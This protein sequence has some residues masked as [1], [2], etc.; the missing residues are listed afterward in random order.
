ML[1]D[2]LRRSLGLYGTNKCLIKTP[3]SSVRYFPS[4]LIWNKRRECKHVKPIGQNYGRPPKPQRTVS[5]SLSSVR[6]SVYE[7]CGSRTRRGFSPSC[8]FKCNVQTVGV[9]G[10]LFLLSQR[11]NRKF[12][13]SFNELKLVILRVLI[14]LFIKKKKEGDVI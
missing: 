2:E 4:T 9:P 12:F 3:P 5:V 6:L 7:Q 11:S 8:S 10:T 1:E 13:Y 14:F